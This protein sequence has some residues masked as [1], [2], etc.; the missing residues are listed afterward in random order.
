MFQ[1]GNPTVERWPLKT[2]SM[3]PAAELTEATL[4]ICAG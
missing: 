3:I 4:I 2:A 1:V